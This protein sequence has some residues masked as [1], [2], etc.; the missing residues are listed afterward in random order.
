MTVAISTK[1]ICVINSI[2]SPFRKENWRFPV[3][4][5]SPIRSTVKNHMFE[6]IE[7]VSQKKLLV[8]NIDWT[9]DTL[10]L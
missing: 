10:N 1:E 3:Y 5:L 9:E 4:L 7:G 8:K 2:W 6:K